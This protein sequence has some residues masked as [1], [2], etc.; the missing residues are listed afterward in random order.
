MKFIIDRED[1]NGPQEI[2]RTAMRALL[3]AD[4]NHN[5]KLFLSINNA[6]WG[7]V[8]NYSVKMPHGLQNAGAT[9]LA[10]A[11][12]IRQISGQ[13]FLQCR[14]GTSADASQV[15]MRGFGSKTYQ[16]LKNHLFK[17][18]GID[19]TQPLPDTFPWEECPP[20]R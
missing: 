9:C 20:R 5:P 19:I 15:Y 3:D 17:K 18:Y 16:C 10:D 11:T 2:T 6:D 1:G 8:P 7:K 4:E 12:C 14:P 13:Y